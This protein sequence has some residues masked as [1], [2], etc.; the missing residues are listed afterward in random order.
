MRHIKTA[1][2]TA[3]EEWQAQRVRDRLE[4]IGFPVPGPDE[5]LIDPRSMRPGPQ[6]ANMIGATAAGQLKR[7]FAQLDARQQLRESNPCR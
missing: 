1:D 7:L 6:P 4:E 2:M 3:D 5:T